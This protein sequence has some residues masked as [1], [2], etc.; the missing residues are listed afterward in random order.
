MIKS[1]NG[2]ALIDCLISSLVNFL[3]PPFFLF[4]VWGLRG[5]PL[6]SGFGG[7]TNPVLAL[8]VWAYKSNACRYDIST[9]CYDYNMMIE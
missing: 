1:V 9:N 3:L 6:T 7:Y 5:A 8:V 4:A 2:L